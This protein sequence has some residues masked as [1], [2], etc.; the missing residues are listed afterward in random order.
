MPLDEKEFKR[1]LEKIVSDYEENPSES[2][3]YAK[4]LERTKYQYAKD[5][6]KKYAKNKTN[7]MEEFKFT[8]EMKTKAFDDSMN[9][10]GIVHLLMDDNYNLS[11]MLERDIINPIKQGTFTVFAII[12]KMGAGK[13][14]LAQT[15]AFLSRDANK[16]Y[17]HRDVAIHLVWTQADFNRI[18]PILKKG[19][20]VWKDEM[21]K[22]LRTGALVEKWQMNNVL[23][24]IRKY[25]NT[26]I[27]IDPVEV[28]VNICDIYFQAA[29]M[30]FD[31]RTNRFLVLNI[32]NI[33]YRKIR[34]LGHI[35]SKLHNDE[36]FRE[37]YENEKDLFI[38]RILKDSGDVR[39]EKQKKIIDVKEVKEEEP[40]LL[41]DNHA[42][43]EKSFKDNITE[44]KVF[45]TIKKE[46]KWYKTERDIEIFKEHKNGKL[47]EEIMKERN[48]GEST[49]KRAIRQIQGAIYKYK[50]LLFEKEYFKW[51]K[52]LKIY[53]KVILDG[54]SGK[55]DIYA[56]DKNKKRLHIFSLKNYAI[57]KRPFYIKT[58]LFG[59]ELKKAYKEHLENNYKEIKVF[60]VV[61]DSIANKTER[62]EL[63]YL[64]PKDITLH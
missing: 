33:L 20:I 36:E 25:E 28:K 48:M 23:H 30:N 40:L 27:F 60:A 37:W 41:E 43:E 29:G 62:I 34:Y 46:V 21:P 55:P 53:D 56:Y 10:L 45:A 58:E 39:A 11:K 22:T 52:E 57:K 26:L 5:F 9:E 47:I 15:I 32:D 54:A 61:Y 44:E 17:K 19:D 35:Y 7:C 8:S 16:K 42:I 18:M 31:T 12:G 51:L 2:D 38:R 6:L 64:N 14:E 59:A 49:V 4:S 13:S 50:G 63:D 1:K 24:V 3:G